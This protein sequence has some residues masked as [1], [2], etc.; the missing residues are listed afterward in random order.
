MVEGPKVSIHIVMF[1]L[2][3]GLLALHIPGRYLLDLK[4][5]LLY[6][7]MSNIVQS[8]PPIMST[9]VEPCG[10]TVGK[11]GYNDKQKGWR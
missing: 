8:S 3:L 9:L 2:V 10:A 6:L 1:W 4:S 7:A 11:T 5:T